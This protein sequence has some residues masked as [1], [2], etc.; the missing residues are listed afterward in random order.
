VLAVTV[1]VLEDAQKQ[2]KRALEN[3]RYH[4]D[5]CFE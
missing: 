4:F 5:H 2:E 3:N 1:C